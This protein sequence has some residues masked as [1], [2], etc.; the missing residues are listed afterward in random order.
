MHSRCTQLPKWHFQNIS[1]TTSPSLSHLCVPQLSR[2]WSPS[3]PRRALYG[4]WPQLLS[5][6]LVSFLHITLPGPVTGRLQLLHLLYV[7]SLHPTPPWTL[8]AL[9]QVYIVFL[10]LPT[11]VTSTLP[12]FLDWLS[13]AYFP[14]ET[15]SDHTSLQVVPIGLP[16]P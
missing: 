6:A 4:L 8:P 15:L 16:P 2:G 1:L 5:P 10:N 7:A 13:S 12:S 3:C 11:Q 9:P 14:S